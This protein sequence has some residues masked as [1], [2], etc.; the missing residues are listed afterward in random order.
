MLALIEYSLRVSA[1][2]LRNAARPIVK[3]CSAAGRYT[4]DQCLRQVPYPVHLELV[5]KAILFTRSPVVGVEADTVSFFN[6]WRCSARPC[7]NQA[8]CG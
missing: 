4:S 1:V 8:W 3:P 2:Q 6:Q 5:T 7:P